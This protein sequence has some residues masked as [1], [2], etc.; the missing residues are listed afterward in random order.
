MNRRSEFCAAA[1]R[2]ARN[3]LQ[4]LMVNAFA[5][6]YFSFRAAVV[7]LSRGGGKMLSADSAEQFPSREL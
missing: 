5:V 3:P 4:N 7:F 1:Q 2:R 6:S